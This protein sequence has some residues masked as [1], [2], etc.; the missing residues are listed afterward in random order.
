MYV[1]L[2]TLLLADCFENFR[3]LCQKQYELDPCY[4]ISTQGLAF[5]V[6]LKKTQV[7]LELLT[8]IDM[9]LMIENGIRGGITQ[10]IHKCSSANNKYME[11][12][13]VDIL[14]SYLMYLDINNLYGYAMCR[15]LPLNGF[16]WVRN[17]AKITNEFIMNYDAETSEKG[18]VLEADI[19]YPKELYKEHS[20]LPFCPSKNEK[21]TTNTKY[22]SSIQKA[23]KNNEEFLSKPN[24]KLLTTLYDKEKY[25]VQIT[26][27]Q[28]A[29]K[30]GLKLKKK[31]RA[32]SFRHSNWLKP[33]IYLNT[34]LRSEAKN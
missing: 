33:Y 22:T 17:L 12:Y 13:I 28:Q 26:T 31:H 16:K 11:S 1:Q 8:D 20:E 34:K 3:N 21:P 23:T 30:Y 6:F 7:K 24:Q 29:L 32:I 18:Y 9:I 27:L 14:S 19:E 15:K 10:A 2:D 4:F 25:V 5:E